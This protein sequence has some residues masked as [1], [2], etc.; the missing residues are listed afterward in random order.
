M[1][2]FAE[3]DC[4]ITH[5]GRSYT[6]NGA[7]ISDARIVCYIGN[8][9]TVTDWHGNVI[10]TYRVTSSRPAVFFG[11]RSF[12]GSRYYYMRV[13]LHDGRVYAVRGFGKSMIA[14]GK[15]VKGR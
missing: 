10:G 15:R 13:T 7:A 1:E 12:Y 4:T 5:A 11:R 9:N 3:T 8:D 14:Q 6:A 2:N